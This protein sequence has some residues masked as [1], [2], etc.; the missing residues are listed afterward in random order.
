[1]AEDTLPQERLYELM[2]IY[3]GIMKVFEKNMELNSK[4]NF[5]LPNKSWKFTIRFAVLLIF[6]GEAKC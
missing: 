6:K 2:H 1:M 5:I 4:V 3:E